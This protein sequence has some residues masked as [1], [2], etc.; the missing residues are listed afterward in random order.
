MTMLHIYDS[1][2]GKYM[3][4]Q[5]PVIDPLET[6]KKGEPVYCVYPYSTTDELP[7]YGEHELPFRINDE[8]VVKGQYKNCEVYNKDSKNFEYCQNDELAENQVFIDDKEGI[9]EYKKTAHKYMVD[10][11]TW[12]I[13]ENP[14]FVLYQQ[15][16]ELNK[17]MSESES[18]YNDALETPVE[19]PANE[20][21]YKAKWVDDGTY[22]K[23]IVGKTAGLFTFPQPIWDA[24]KL[25]ENMVMM[26]ELTFGQLCGFLAQVQ[27][28]A[29]NTRKTL[30][31][32][33]TKKIAKVQA[34][35]DDPDWDPEHDDD[36][37]DV[38]PI[39]VNELLQSETPAGE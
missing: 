11:E 26:D 36:P 12:T 19:F 23:L 15:L 7:T 10:E 31:S 35:I 8:W 24:T 34:K 5:E 20:H 39:D 28:V 9:E 17:Q 16:D 3:R 13:V 1:E 25:E 27:N 22:E 29:F 18:A 33:L 37:V 2:T 32:A 14:K 21:L 38:T 30:Q 6:K 4:S